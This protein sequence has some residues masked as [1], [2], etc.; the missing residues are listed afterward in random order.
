VSKDLGRFAA[1]VVGRAVR[2]DD[3]GTAAIVVA[4]GLLSLRPPPTSL[5]F[6]SRGQTGGQPLP[7]VS[8]E[9]AGTG[10]KPDAE[11]GLEREA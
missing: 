1:K 2:I 3:C 5:R 6:D 11:W 8:V 4:E 7:L 9:H 10:E